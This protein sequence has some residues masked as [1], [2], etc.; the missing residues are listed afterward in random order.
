MVL[1]A[2][3]SLFLL[4]APAAQPLR[5][6]VFDGYQRLFPLERITRPVAVVVIDEAALARYGQWPW[7]RTRMAELITRIASTSRPAIGVDLLFSEPD[8]FSPAAIAAEIPI[9]RRTSRARREALPSNDKLFADAIRGKNV[10]VGI[11]GG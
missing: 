3:L 11:A 9:R 5:N 4:L 7:P 10:V 2:A 8:R 6:V 1:L